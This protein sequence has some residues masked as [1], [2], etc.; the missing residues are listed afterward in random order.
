MMIAIKSIFAAEFYHTRKNRNKE[1]RQEREER[2]GER[3]G[4]REGNPLPI[5]SQ[6]NDM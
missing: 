6:L 5:E 3:K 1:G 2:E 4:G